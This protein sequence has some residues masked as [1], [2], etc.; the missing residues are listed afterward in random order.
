MTYDINVLT[1]DIRARLSDYRFE[2]SLNVA[3]SAKMLAAKYGGDIEKAFLAGLMH[4]V[5]KDA[6]KLSTLRFFEQHGVSLTRLEA[7]APKLWHAVSGAFYLKEVYGFDDDIISA[8][9]YHTTGRENMSLLEKIVFIADFISADRDYPGVDE[10]RE[11]ARISL[12]RAMEEGLRFTI[13]ELS[14]KCAPIH[15]DTLACYNQI[16]LD[17]GEK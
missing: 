2:H 14:E 1:A 7:N 9:R 4:D 15:P 8:V 5:L 11:R 17:K 16:I 3:E 6:D 10:M 13:N 12:E